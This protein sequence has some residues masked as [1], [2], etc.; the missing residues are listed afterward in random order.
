MAH[1]CGS[2]LSA[3]L[4]NDIWIFASVLLTCMQE[5]N[6][7]IKFNINVTGFAKNGLIAGVRKL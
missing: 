3:G 5:K 6:V 7:I 4:I 2:Q 1:S